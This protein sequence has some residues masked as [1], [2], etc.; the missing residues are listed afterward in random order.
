MVHL[1]CPMESNMVRLIRADVLVQRVVYGRH[2]I[3]NAVVG[4]RSCRRA[5]RTQEMT[6]SPRIYRT[7]PGESSTVRHGRRVSHL[8]QRL[9]CILSIPST[10]VGRSCRRGDNTTDSHE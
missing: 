10:A 3:L 4:G 6:F 5:G 7:L 2:L 8:V 9:V 1:P